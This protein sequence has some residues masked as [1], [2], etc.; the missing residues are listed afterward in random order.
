MQNLLNIENERLTA[1]PDPHLTEVKEFKVLIDSDDTKDKVKCR[2]QFAAIWNMHNPQSP[3]FDIAKDARWHEIVDSIF[4]GEFEKTE[5]FKKA[6]EKYIKLSETKIQKLLKSAHATIDKLSVYFEEVDPLEKD[7]NGKLI[8]R[9]KDI[10][11]N[12]S[13]L[14]DV[15]E[16]LKSLEESVAK[17]Q[18]QTESRG[19]IKLNKFN[20]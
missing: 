20:R 4:D 7:D 6:E 1:Y 2:R 14:S 12:I 8:W 5:E 11:A 3:F 13:K 17:E 19:D 15:V 9:A 16:G 18:D 10:I